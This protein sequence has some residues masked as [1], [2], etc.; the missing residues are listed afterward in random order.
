MTKQL[1]M[2]INDPVDRYYIESYTK[3]IT[4][5]EGFADM[6]ANDKFLSDTKLLDTFFQ[7]IQ[8]FSLTNPD[9][10]GNITVR[11]TGVGWF[12]EIETIERGLIPVT[13]FM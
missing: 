8:S 7:E 11:I 4:T 3:Y 2:F 13:T 6:L 10:N 1:Y 5:V 9:H 12:H